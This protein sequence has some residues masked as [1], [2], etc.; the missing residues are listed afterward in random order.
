MGHAQWRSKYL[1]DLKSRAAQ[2]VTKSSENSSQRLSLG[3]DQEF[4]DK[5]VGFKFGFQDM[6]DGAY[7]S[8]PDRYSAEYTRRNSHIFIP[9]DN[10]FE[11]SSGGLLFRAGYQQVVWGEAFGSFFA[12]V[13][14]PKDLRE[15][16]LNSLAEQRLQTPMINF[17]W[18]EKKW[19]MQGIWIPQPQ[20]NRNPDPGG[21]FFVLP[22]GMTAAGVNYVTE[23]T[24]LT[25]QNNQSFETEFGV[26][27]TALLGSWDFSLFALNAYDRSP[28]YT[29][30]VTSLAPMTV[31]LQPHSVTYNLMGMTMTN[32]FDGVVLRMEVISH[33]KRPFQ[34]VVNSQLGYRRSNQ[35]VSVVGLD[36]TQF[37]FAQI[38]LQISR[39]EVMEHD[40]DLFRKK[41]QDLGQ[42]R[43]SREWKNHRVEAS[44]SD[45]LTEQGYLLQSSY[46]YVMSRSTELHL[47]VDYFDGVADSQ[48]G[49]LREAS[50]FYLMIEM[51][52]AG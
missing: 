16:G 1:L 11:Y 32:D 27:A 52:D 17:K 3:F 9:R 48:A 5:P 33:Q 34:N 31:T 22:A 4:Q 37:E 20:F 30:R 50:R 35:L 38:G 25:E 12:D 24:V 42:I 44:L 21:D 41:N 28:Y 2:K 18:I 8:N 43:I 40:A 36:L 19:S 39:D 15:A 7:G 14:N 6:V 46:A 26:R 49:Q 47:G 13:V 10:Y 45:F 29:S 51:K 23:S